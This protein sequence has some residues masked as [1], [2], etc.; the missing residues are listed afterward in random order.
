MPIKWSAGKVNDAAN[1]ME[2]FINQAT[3][4][5]ESVRLVA[6]EARKILNLP[7]YVGQDFSRI[8]GEIERA[9]GGGYLEPVGRL[10]SCIESIRKDIPDGA[11]KGEVASQR[12]GTT[13]S[14][15]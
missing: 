9:I 1:M 3:E 14:L 13:Q 8:I 5:L 2:A 7:Q 4:P 10:R 11:I 6:E 15:M 12:H